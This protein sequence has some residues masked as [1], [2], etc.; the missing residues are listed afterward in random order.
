M[1]VIVYTKQTSSRLEYILSTLLA[2][3]GIADFI[4]TT[5][6]DF[7]KDHQG[8]KLNYS[9]TS[10]VENEVWIA[11]VTLLFENDIKH[12]H[13][14]VFLWK[15]LP[16][17]FKTYSTDVPFDLF[18]AS[19]YLIARYE[20]YLPHSSDAYGR[21]AHENSTAYKNNFLQIPL[22]NLWLKQLAQ[23]FTDRFPAIHLMPS[24]FS[25]LPTYDIDIAW[26]YLNKG[27]LRN[28]GGF[29]RLMV[30]GQWLMVK[31]RRNVILRKQQD[32]FDSYTWLNE[33]HDKTNLQPLY[34][35][36]IAKHSK[37]YDK[38]ILPSNANYRQLINNLARMYDVGLHP[39]WQSGDD[40]K[41]LAEELNTLS[42]ITAKTI[43]KSRQHYIRMNFPNT[44]R[45]LLAAE[46]TEDYSMGYG[47][48]N[49][50]RA[51]YCLPYK[52][53]DL[54]KETITSLV[55]YPFC[56]MEANS[57]YEQKYSAAEAQQELEHYYRVTKDVNG[58]LIT[59][60]H[61]H[62]LGTDKMFEGWRQVYER[63]I[64]AHSSLNVD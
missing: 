64:L 8:A 47:S 19:F 18:A 62:L 34:F 44:Y 20:E 27:W 13:T 25:Y 48:I 40:E 9:S 37:G 30:N 63:F 39:S 15:E 17:F 33:L 5:E 46:I 26:S 32:P 35:F 58:L 57:F 49:G 11:P 59:I 2:A 23:L 24:A 21:Y 29:I 31:E 52:W 1:Q 41:L 45:R 12:Q 51:S 61:N 10:I 60:W 7:Y 53:Y 14:E 28:A 3:T 42:N 22:I 16:A 6:Q 54:E 36:L 50:F 38:N 56:Y 43:T 4:I 55:V